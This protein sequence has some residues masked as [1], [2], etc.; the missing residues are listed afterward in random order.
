M[1]IILPA[2]LLLIATSAFA[3]S[4]SNTVCVA[5]NAASLSTATS[6]LVTKTPAKKPAAYKPDAT[7]GATRKRKK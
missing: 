1:K 6:N 2:L 7:T 5:T 4:S 3:E